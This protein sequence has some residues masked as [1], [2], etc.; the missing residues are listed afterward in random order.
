MLL[1]TNK[2]SDET[3][4]DLMGAKFKLEA[5]VKAGNVN[6]CEVQVVT[7]TGTRTPLKANQSSYT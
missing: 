6:K 5:E 1:P 4:D 3:L 2:L 7:T